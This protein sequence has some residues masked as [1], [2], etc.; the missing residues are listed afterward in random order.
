MFF[1]LLNKTDGG[2]DD[3]LFDDVLDVVFGP[4]ICEKIDTGEFGIILAMFACAVDDMSAWVHLEPLD[5]LF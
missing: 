3:I 4:L 1:G 2:S 5:V